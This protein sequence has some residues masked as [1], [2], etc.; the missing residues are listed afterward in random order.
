MASP[1]S[2]SAGRKA[3]MWTA[4]YL[5]QLQ[6]QILDQLQQ[7]K[8]EA[9][10]YLTGPGGA[11][12]AITG[13]YGQALQAL[14]QNYGNAAGAYGQAGAM[15]A[16]VQERNLAG[17]DMLGNALGL[18]GAEGNA[19]AQAAFQAGPGYQWQVDQA[20]KA[21]DRRA[22]S[23]GLLTSG[24]AQEATTNLA[25]NLANQEYGKWVTNLQPFQGASNNLAQSQ[26]Q[27]LQ[28]LGNLY[29]QQGNVTA[30]TYGQQAQA[31]GALYG[32]EAQN[33]MTTGESGAN[34]IA[35]IGSQIANVGMQGM[36]AGQQAAQNRMS[37]TMGGLQLGG[38]LLGGIAGLGV[39]G[40]GTLGGNFLSSIFK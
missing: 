21:A 28:N 26:A 19:A 2:G 34:A 10:G 20:T 9:A 7:G 8:T 33:A 15:E 18:G 22:A 25:S 11:S 29:G 1:F 37:A 36:N 30:N 24:N 39:A 40:G 12:E 6:P 16:P 23:L 31:L 13:G 4:G 3:A 5:Q 32:Q 27:I 38:Q 17:Y 14:Q 35:G